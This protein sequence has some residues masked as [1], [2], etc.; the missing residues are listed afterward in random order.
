MT[1]GVM[2]VFLKKI[3]LIRNKPL[4]LPGLSPYPHVSSG[5]PVRRAGPYQ[6]HR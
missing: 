4:A 2:S 3:R 5:E 6:G 1:L